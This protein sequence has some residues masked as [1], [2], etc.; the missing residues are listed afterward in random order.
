[1]QN[2]ADWIERV[3][4]NLKQWKTEV[5]NRTSDSVHWYEKP[6][7]FQI[8]VVDPPYL[9]PNNMPPHI[10]QRVIDCWDKKYHLL[11]ELRN[12]MLVQEYDEN[13]WQLFKQ[14]T[15]EL[16]NMRGTNVLD[17]V[18]QLEGEF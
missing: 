9:N 4:S 11:D 1:M 14:F 5:A 15:R 10:K 16:D 2:L 8:L 3:T 13:K 17:Y 7:Q 12:R 18:P 6:N